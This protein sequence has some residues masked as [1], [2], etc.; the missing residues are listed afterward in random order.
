MENVI[1]VNAFLS[2]KRLEIICYCIKRENYYIFELG[3]KLNK[4]LG[5]TYIF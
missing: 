4:V 2:T 1:I 3:K 5:N